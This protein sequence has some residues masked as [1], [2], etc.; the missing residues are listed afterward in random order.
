MTPFNLLNR[1]NIQIDQFGQTFL[2]HSLRIS[3]AADIATERFE[4][5]LFLRI[6]RHALL[7]REAAKMRNGVMGRKIAL[8]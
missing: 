6:E 7:S 1:S 8:V 3:L 2:R 5:E 4:L